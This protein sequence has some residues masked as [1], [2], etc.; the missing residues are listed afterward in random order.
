[1]NIWRPYTQMKGAAPQLRVRRAQG[2]Y[3]HLEQGEML[4]DGISSW[5]LITHGHCHPEIMQA[6]R[7]QAGC[8]DQVIFANFTHDAAE[9][10]AERLRPLLPRALNSL[11]FSDNGSTSVE[12]AMKMAYQWTRLMG[13]TEKTK[14]CAF[15][16]S[17]H[18]D[19]F[20]AMSIGADGAFTQD[21]RGLRLDVFRCKQGQLSIDP[22]DVWVSDFEATIKLHHHEIIAVILEPMIQGAGGMIIWPSEALERITRLCREYDLLLI[23]DEVMTGFGRTGKIFAFEHLTTVPDFVCLSKGLTGGALPLALTLTSDRIYDAF[24]S[25]DPKKMFFHGHSFTANPIACAAAAANLKLLSDKSVLSRVQEIENAHRRSLAK[26]SEVLDLKDTRTLGAVGAVELNIPV[27]YGGPTSSRVYKDCLQ[28][29]LFLRPLGPVIYLLPPYC[30]KP[31]EIEWAWSLIGEVLA[32]GP[33]K[34][35]RRAL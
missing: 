8:V 7:E 25:E 31:H 28:K 34:K 32:S 23:F 3:L 29:G 15:E 24:L 19:T 16:N 6:I 35:Q 22:L 30:S 20:G 11:F 5:W 9:L 26:L 2:A 14:F 18:G 1:M 27:E 17:Y 10:L 33:P 21:F 12:V 13:Q 4:F